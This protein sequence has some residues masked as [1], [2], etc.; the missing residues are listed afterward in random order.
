MIFARLQIFP[1]DQ[2]EN[3][4]EGPCM[5]HVW[6]QERYRI[7][8]GIIYRMGARGRPSRRW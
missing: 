7:L 1:G 6:V 8:V 5:W 4:R 2:I 3:K